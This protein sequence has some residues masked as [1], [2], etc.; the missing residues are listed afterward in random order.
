[1]Q[2]NNNYIYT[3]QHTGFKIRMRNQ[4]KSTRIYVKIAQIHINCS[5]TVEYQVGNEEIL[6]NNDKTILPIDPDSDYARPI[7]VDRR[8]PV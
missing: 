4:R 1:M 7:L 5:N 8:H 2:D 3:V 6:H